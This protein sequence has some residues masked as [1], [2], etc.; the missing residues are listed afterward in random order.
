MADQATQETI[1]AEFS[2]L[3]PVTFGLA[4]GIMWSLGVFLLGIMATI[5]GWGGGIVD[6]LSSLYIGY[7]PTFVGSIVGLVWG[8]ADA[9]IGG[10]VLAWLYNWLLPL[11]RCR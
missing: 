4:F 1:S 10:I 5:S 7:G 9:F 3:A 11:C 6:G 8:F 2:K